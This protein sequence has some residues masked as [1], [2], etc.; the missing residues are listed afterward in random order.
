MCPVLDFCHALGLVASFLLLKMLFITSSFLLLVARPGATSS[1]LAPSYRLQ[2]LIC[3]CRI[4]TR[5]Q[6]V[7]RGLQHALCG[8]V[9]SCFCIALSRVPVDHTPKRAGDTSQIHD[10]RHFKTLW[11]SAF[12]RLL[13]HPFSKTGF[14]LDEKASHRA[15]SLD[16]GG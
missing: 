15:R 9:P 7:L 14:R 10:S 6:I 13:L 1:V 12:E 2:L 4:D 16:A 11:C 5:G 8:G 3:K